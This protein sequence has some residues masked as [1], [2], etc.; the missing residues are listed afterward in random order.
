ML[1]SKYLYVQNVMLDATEPPH[2]AICH[3]YTFR[4]TLPM[5]HDAIHEVVILTHFSLSV[6]AEDVSPSLFLSCVQT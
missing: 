6:I 1:M 4:G 2:N 5:M 3:A